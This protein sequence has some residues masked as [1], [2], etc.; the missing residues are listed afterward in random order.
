MQV[1][2]TGWSKDI[3]KQGVSRK[4]RPPGSVLTYDHGADGEQDEGVPAQEA[5]HVLSSHGLQAQARAQ[6][7]LV[8][9]VLQPLQPAHPAK[10]LAAL[11]QEQ[12]VAVAAHGLSAGTEEPRSEGGSVEGGRMGGWWPLEEAHKAREGCVHVLGCALARTPG[13]LPGV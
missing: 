4:S 2:V 5:Q 10:A 7:S 11:P 1:R 13:A 3:C 9:A 6:R 12:A 8:H